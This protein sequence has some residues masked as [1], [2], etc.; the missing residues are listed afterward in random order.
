MP[1]LGIQPPLA[2]DEVDDLLYFTRVNE[3]QD[4]QDTLSELAQKY[5][6]PVK[7]IVMNAVDPKSRNTLLHYSSANGLDGLLKSILSLVSVPSETNEAVSADSAVIA[8]VNTANAE[9]NTA[10]HW[11]ALNGHVEVVKTLIDAGV[12]IWVKNANGDMA[13]FEAERAERTAVVQTLLDA[14]LK[15]ADKGETEHLP[16]A[17]DIFRSEQEDSSGGVN[18]GSQANEGAEADMSGT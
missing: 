14:S 16:L 17:A 8:W 5:D 12:D 2:A 15:K 10:L 4:L 9:G 13:L 7:D 3:L 18:A 11:A 1:L 6:Y